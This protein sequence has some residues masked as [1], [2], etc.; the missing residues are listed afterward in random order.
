MGYLIYRKDTTV[1]PA[2]LRD[3]RYKTQAAAKAA[4][5]RFN[6]AWAQTRGK[7]GN[8]P[9]APV[10]TMG[11]AEEVYFHE[12]IE[13]T[14]E[15]TNLMSGQAYREPVNTPGYMSPASEAYWSM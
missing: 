7:L 5:T 4:L 9:D 6:K 13:K 14:V 10:F 11:I 3:R 12:H 8:E 15:R 2:Q 1:I